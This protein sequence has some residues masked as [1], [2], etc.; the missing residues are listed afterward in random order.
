[1]QVELAVYDALQSANV[2][3]DKAKAVAAAITQAIDQRYE[4]H[5]KQLATR[6]DLSDLRKDVADMESRLTRLMSDNMRWTITTLIAGM[7]MMVAVLK[8]L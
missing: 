2:P 6:G 3:S 4:L 7:A 1:M 5:A 8:L